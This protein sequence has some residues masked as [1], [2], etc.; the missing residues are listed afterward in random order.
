MS[1][2]ISQIV[3]FL[4]AEDAPTATEYA[5]MLVLIVPVV[6]AV[7]TSLGKTVSGTFS[8]ASSALGVGS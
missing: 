7:I 2:I 8:S 6:I 5:V 1:T 3:Q 4:A